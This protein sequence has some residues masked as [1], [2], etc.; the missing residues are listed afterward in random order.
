MLKLPKLDSYLDFDTSRQEMTARRELNRFVLA[1]FHIYFLSVSSN[2]TI[3][4]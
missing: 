1:N 4:Q 2:D 3:K